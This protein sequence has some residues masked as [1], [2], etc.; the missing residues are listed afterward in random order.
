MEIGLKWVGEPTDYIA[1]KRME[2]GMEIPQALR[3]ALELQLTGMRQAQMMHDAQTISM[4]YR[5]QSGKGERLLTSDAEA[6]A[7]A[8]ARMPATFGAVYV[9]LEQALASAGCLPQTLLDAGA[10]TGAAAW[11]ADAQLDLKSI[12]CLERE[13]AMRRTG[14]AMMKQGPQALR[15]AKWIPHDLTTDEISERSDLVVA[16]YVL[17]EMTDAGRKKTAEKLWN[18][19]K[20]LLLLVE[21]G[22]P[23]GFSHLREARQ[24]LL[25]CGAHIAAPCPCEADCPKTQDDWCHFSCRVGRSR[26]HRQLKGGEAPYEDEK[27]IYMALTREGSRC[28]GARVLRHPQVRGGHVMLEV[29]TADGIRDIKLSKKD[30]ERYKQAR[31]AKSGEQIPY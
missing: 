19:A 7:Y 13:D 12:V 15:D 16:S 6:V 29:C 31:K 25:E 17:N 3:E 20:M 21:P 30:G 9:A 10:G 5:T 23:A 1:G 28:T 26:L 18:A 8:T 14:E 27:F 24:T 4:R 22:T 2:K 11:A